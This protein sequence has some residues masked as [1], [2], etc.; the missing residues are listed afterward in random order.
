[1]PVQQPHDSAGASRSILAR[2]RAA[3]FRLFTSTRSDK[4]R[5]KDSNLH[6]SDQT[7]KFN[8]TRPGQ[9][10]YLGTYSPPSK[11]RQR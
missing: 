11:Y 5:R 1:M 8:R 3:I 6:Y 4:P 9:P 7:E 10:G 2:L